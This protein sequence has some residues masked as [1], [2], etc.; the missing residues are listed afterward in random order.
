MP[1]KVGWQTSEFW[2]VLLTNIV[3]IFNLF[4]PVSMTNQSLA[5]IAGI[6]AMVCTSIAYIYGRSIVKS[7][8]AAP[9][10]TTNV[11]TTVE[12]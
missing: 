7:K 12:K 1:P 4:H 3:G 2:I 9:I 8:M 5:Q 6:V 11:T 10:G